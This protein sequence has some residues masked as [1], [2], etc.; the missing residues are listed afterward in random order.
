MRIVHAASELF[1]FIKTGGLADAVGALTRELAAMGHEVAVFLPGYRAVLE[2]PELRDAR[3]IHALGIEMDDRFYHGEV[4]AKELAPRLTLYLICRDEYFDRRF[5]YGIAARDYEDNAERFLFFSKAVVEVLSHIRFKADIVHC[6]DWQTALI[7]ALLRFEEQRRGTLLAGKTVLTIHNLAFQGIFPMRVFSKT[8]LPDELRGVDGLEFYGQVN[9]L[10]GGIL[11]SDWI[12]TV[13]PTYCRE[14][15][16]PEFGCGLEGVLAT[17]KSDLFCQINGIDY[18][19]WNPEEDPH[20]PANYSA[21]DL[22]GKKVCRRHLLKQL[23]LAPKAKGKAGGP[24]FGMICRFAEQKGL[25][26]LR[27]CMDDL[28]QNDSRLII[29]GNGSPSYEQWLNEVAEAN[30]GR[31]SVSSGMDERL[32]H[33]IEAGSDFFLMPS[34][35]EPCGLNQMYSMRYG[36]VPLVSRV[37]GLADTVVDIDD[38]PDSGTGITFP[39]TADGLREGIRR[40]F[41]LY[42]D[43]RRMKSVIVRGMKQDFSWRKAARGYA[44]LYEDAL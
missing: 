27:A 33:L 25:E 38:D 2:A 6:H 1:P 44:R 18:D 9:F 28:L 36:T 7:P 37:G 4:L 30:P 42:A 14:I 31:V 10:K 35:F 12:T 13:S 11:F 29:L 19:V 16:T 32:S 41:A 5:P 8:G 23:S 40:A 34:I 22:A 15:L 3:R 43:T 26:L 24:I 21:E 20:L 17:R 39:P